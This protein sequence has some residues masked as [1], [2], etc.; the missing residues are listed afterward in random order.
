MT[1]LSVG[2]TLYVFI[3]HIS[4]RNAEGSLDNFES[5]NAIS[6]KLTSDMFVNKTNA[7]IN[8]VQTIKFKIV[9]CYFA[10]ELHLIQLQ[11]CG[12]QIQDWLYHAQ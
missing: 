9:D 1:F 12:L 3:H 8:C 2:F 6:F 7:E 10:H 5:L 4:L 11:Q